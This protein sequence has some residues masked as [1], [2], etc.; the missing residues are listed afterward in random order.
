MSDWTFRPSHGT[1]HIEARIAT[2]RIS[3]ETTDDESIE[4]SVHGSAESSVEVSQLGDT[5]II[6]QPRG[7]ARASLAV[8]VRTPR[9]SNVTISGAA[10]DCRIGGDVGEVAVKTA[11]GDVRVESA[12]RANIKTASGNVEVDAVGGP[13]VVAGAA[14]DVRVG[15]ATGPV[16]VSVASG[17]TRIGVA[18]DTVEVTTVSGDVY[19][20]VSHG[21]S[22]KVKALSGDF[23]IGLPTGVR[24]EPDINTM[25]GTVKVPERDPDASA[26]TRTVQLTARTTSGNVEIRRVS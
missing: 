26:P 12:S 13:I 18:R 7:R 4:V 6:Q 5:I 14:A 17:D 25:T 20:G 16:S 24:V 21:P 9:N 11:S 8:V 19:I 3:V 10:L 2:G 15:E 22:I 23:D 1:P